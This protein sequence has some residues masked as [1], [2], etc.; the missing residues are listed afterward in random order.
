MRVQ[1]GICADS[2]RTSCYRLRSYICQEAC[3]VLGCKGA[4]VDRDGLQEPRP[5][6]R[7]SRPRMNGSGGSL[8][9]A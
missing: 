4:G 1:N 5:G 6:L 2:T 8:C 3:F 9:Q 7:F